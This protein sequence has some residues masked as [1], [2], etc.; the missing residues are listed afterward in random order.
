[1]F[2][3]TAPLWTDCDKAQALLA[4]FAENPPT[5][6][7]HK[8]RYARSFDEWTTWEGPVVEDLADVLADWFSKQDEATLKAG[9][10]S[11][12]EAIDAFLNT[13]RND[14]HGLVVLVAD[15]VAA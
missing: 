12:E 6:V 5:L 9:W 13:K 10:P 2:P 1:M 3:T 14:W 8:V 15:R 4:S 7:R 11:V